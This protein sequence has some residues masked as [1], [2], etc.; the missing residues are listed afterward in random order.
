[1]KKSIISLATF[2]GALL[3][4]KIQAF[5]A[6]SGYDIQNALPSGYGGWGNTYTGTITTN[7]SYV[8]DTGGSGTMN[9]G[10]IES[11]P[12]TTELLSIGSNT[13][14]TLHL[15]GLY[16]I[17]NIQIYQG[18]IPDNMIPGQLTGLTVG[19]GN[20]SVGYTMSGFGSIDPANGLPYDGS[21]TLNLTQNAIS[22]NLLTL[23]NFQ[24]GWDNLFSIAEITLNNQQ[25][26]NNA[27]NSVPEPATM[28]L[29]GAGLVGV[30]GFVRRKRS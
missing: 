6:I 11:T 12:Q 10:V 23:S 28:A 24:G 26:T 14:I 8:N 25:N 30:A 19:I 22:T 29:F 5:A 7:G 20:T 27:N 13:V 17:S 16:S 15:D 21:V 2:L 18:D 4:L 9:N 1:M 3:I